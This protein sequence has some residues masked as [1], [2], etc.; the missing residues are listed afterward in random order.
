MMKRVLAICLLLLLTATVLAEGETG[1][2]G[3]G[4]GPQ[5]PYSGS[6]EV[7]FEKT[8][9]YMIFMPLNQSTVTPGKLILQILMP[10]EDVEIGS[11]TITLYNGQD[12]VVEEIPFDEEHVKQ[13][14]MTEAELDAMIWGCGTVFSVKTSNPPEANQS[15]YVL[16]TDGCIIAPDYGTE[17]LPLEDKA[18]WTFN[19]N[20]TN[21]VENFAYSHDN[22]NIEA[23]DE[24][25][26]EEEEET[27]EEPLEAPQLDDFA[28]FSIVLDGTGITAVIYCNEGSIATEDTYVTES[29]DVSVQFVSVGQTDWG[30]MFLKE[31]GSILYQVDYSVVVSDNVG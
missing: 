6:P 27:E 14:A 9:G 10:R 8:I 11:G 25:E 16:M 19:T 24:T 3:E 5:K 13:R 12:E 28:N 31:D 18:K 30:V 15:F 20:V 23:D 29:K 1:K 17:T 7:D 26:P 4:L 22:G 2:W 21:Y